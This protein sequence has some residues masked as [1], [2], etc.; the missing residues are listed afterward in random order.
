MESGHSM[1]TKSF[2]NCQIKDPTK[3]IVTKQ[4]GLDLQQEQERYTYHS[5]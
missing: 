4:L 3:T 2:P 1:E 5:M